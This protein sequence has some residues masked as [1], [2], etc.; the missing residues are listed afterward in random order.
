MFN[1]KLWLLNNLAFVMDGSFI[2]VLVVPPQ[3]ARLTQ[4]EP[5]VL[6]EEEEEGWEI[7]EGEEGTTPTSPT[8]DTEEQRGEEGEEEGEEEEEEK[9]G[10]DSDKDDEF[11]QAFGSGEEEDD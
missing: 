9:E 11:E 2:C 7:E 4:L 10:R 6:E 1:R 5:A 3:E 8:E